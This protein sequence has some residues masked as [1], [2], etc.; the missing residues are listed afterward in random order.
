MGVTEEG[1]ETSDSAQMTFHGNCFSFKKI[2]EDD[3]LTVLRA[4]DTNKAVGVDEISAKLLRIT[5]PS[6]ARSLASLF[7][8]SLE[9]GQVSGME[10]CK[11]ISCAERKQ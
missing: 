6:I 7:N 10:I 8:F 1:N 3:V 2:D 9:H 11:Y 4:L 5:A